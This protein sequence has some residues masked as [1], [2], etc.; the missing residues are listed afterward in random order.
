MI[1][2]FVAVRIP[3]NVIEQLAEIQQQLKREFTDV[4][5][6]RPEA[7]H[8]TLHF[9]GNVSTS[10]LS[11][12]N[13][14]LNATASAH[15][16]FNLKLGSLG[17]FGQRVLWVG[18]ESGANELT[19]LANAV[20]FSIRPFGSNDET[21]PFNA[22]ATLGRFRERG[23]GVDTALRRI[24]PPTLSPWR[25]ND[26]ELIRSELSPKGSRYTMLAAFP[27]AHR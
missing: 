17:S 25:V 11:D 26:V 1:R 8:L 22:H 27:L 6:T 12:L 13:E 20:R 19:N 2:A 9:F 23:R 18:V 7:M 24:S 21:R 5:W 16:S 3:P 10:C 4:S 15:P 14:R